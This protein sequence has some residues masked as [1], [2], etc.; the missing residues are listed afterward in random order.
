MRLRI[1]A[2]L[3]AVLF[4]FALD[5]PLLA[6]A[7]QAAP[8]T[9]NQ[10]TVNGSKSL[11][12]WRRTE[13][14]H[15]IF[16]SD[17]SEK[18]L[19][20]DA[21]KLERY[22]QLMRLLTGIGDDKGQVKLTVYFVRST[23]AVQALYPG[24][25]KSIG[26]FYSPSP[27]GAII[28]VPRSIDAYEGDS[29]K[30]AETEDVVLFHEYAHHLMQQYF[31]AAYPAWYIEGFAEFIG[32]A[33]IETNGIASYGIVNIS[34]APTLF[35][36][37]GI[38]IE[39]LLTARVSDLKTD[40]VSRFYAYSWL[41]THYLSFGKTRKGQLANFLA[42]VQAG[43]AA[44][45]AAQEV[46]GDLKTLN[47][48]LDIYK[49][50]KMVYTKLNN[51]LPEPASFA[52]G[53]LDEGSSKA[54]LL[55]LKLTRSTKP[56]EREPIA[57]ELR[58]LATRFP[59]SPAILTALAEAELDLGNYAAGGTAAEAAIALSST[60]SR[61]LL[62][63]GLSLS[64]P[65]AKA[66]DRDAAKWKEARGWI[67]KANRANPNDPLALMEYFLSFTIPGQTP[68]D[69]A[70]QGIGMAVSLVPQFPGTRF[71]YAGALANQKKF[72]EAIRVLQPLASNPHGGKMTEYVRNLIAQL[73][74]AQKGGL[75]LPPD[76]VPSLP[77]D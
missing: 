77:E 13:T 8:S 61:A 69:I 54:V 43:K 23:S 53:T 4:P 15:F 14:E 44:L 62:W 50:G 18:E 42:A 27:A 20:S 72:P 67:V 11:G 52:I 28:V 22:D 3:G 36:D 73:E 38:S 58:G 47:R 40:D 7:P 63:K 57:A 70:I 45:V 2:G 34:R 46:F 5:F 35:M 74:T 26:G 60:N 51:P 24:P 17:G 25:V 9:A 55:Q 41:L 68:P 49:T 10:I 1:L 39:K 48:E 33:R 21:I 12:N 29:R 56:N 75:V 16:Y 30:F 65:L 64:R 32:N 37:S 71:M 59:G 6:Q 31:P 19:R 66:K 76:L